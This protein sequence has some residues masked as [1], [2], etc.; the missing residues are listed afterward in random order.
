MKKIKK[1]KLRTR[2]MLTT[3][4]TISL[5]LCT[6]LI[7]SY[8]NTEEAI[9][10]QALYSF[11][12]NVQKTC[13]ILDNRLEVIKDAMENMNLDTRLYEI[14]RNLNQNSPLELLRA[15]QEITVLLRDYFP[16]YSDIYS[17]HL[18]TSYYRFGSEEENYYP[19]FM[20]SE[21]AQKACEAG[22]RSV[23]FPTYSYTQMY[24]ITDLKDEQIPY[25]KLFT[26]ASQLN[27]SDVRSGKVERL[28][29]YTENPL[30][31]INFK[32]E[33]MENVLVKYG[34]TTSLENLEYYVTD[35]EGRIVYSTD[36]SYLEGGRYQAKWLD[37]LDETSKFDGFFVWENGQKYLLS[38]SKS[39]VTGWL[40]VMKIPVSSLVGSLQKQYLQYLIFA[41][42]TMMI[43]SGV[44]TWINSFMINKQFYRVVGTIEGIGQGN[45]AQKIVYEPSDEFAFFYKKLEQMSSDIGNLI[46]ENYEV[47]LMKK[48]TEIKALNAQLNPHFIYNTLN[49]IN[50]TCLEGDMEATSQMLVNLSRMLHYTSHHTELYETLEND[51]EW[52]KRYLYIMQIRFAEKFDVVLDI[53]EEL[54]SMKV[55]KLF[56]QPFVENVL[57]HGFSDMK[58]RGLLEIHAEYEEDMV[59]FYVEDNGCGMSQEKIE[60]IMGG[61]PDSIGIANVNQRIKILYGQ[62]YGAEYHSQMGEGTSVKIKLSK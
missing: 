42:I 60:E 29:T 57:V 59:V 21:I 5:I 22:G 62:E 34:T 56:L 46:H 54:L 31:V 3:F 23:W 9:E 10:N 36:G 14:F 37:A 4:M 39:T 16:W 6:V 47:R 8:K 49:I 40:I 35:L 43:V 1:M 19:S 32:P 13:L 28:S 33:Y 18:L 55:P 17:M 27:L 15:S 7:L 20:D 24:G 2:M 38:Y 26:V 41:F 53:P 50:W 45:F 30:L 51:L 52:L 48:D 25:G 12:E 11:E 44:M 61:N 58:E